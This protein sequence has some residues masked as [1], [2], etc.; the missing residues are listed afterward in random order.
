LKKEGLCILKR[1]VVFEILKAAMFFCEEDSRA[2]TAKRVPEE[3]R[4]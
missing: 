1:R 4:Y 2:G 3:A